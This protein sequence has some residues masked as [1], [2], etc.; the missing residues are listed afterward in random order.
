M[1]QKWPRRPSFEREVPWSCKLHIPQYRGK[2]WEWEGRGVVGVMGNF[3]N[4]TGNVNEE[5]T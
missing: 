5:N 4:I 3:W 1:Y 2:K